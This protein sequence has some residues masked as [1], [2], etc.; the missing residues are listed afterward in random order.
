MRVQK[1]ASNETF[2]ELPNRD[3]SRVFERIA[4]K[5]LWAKEWTH[6]SQQ[7]E[8]TADFTDDGDVM[9]RS[10]SFQSQDKETNE[11]PTS[12][13]ATSFPKRFPSQMTCHIPPHLPVS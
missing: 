3:A 7:K 11:H 1:C 9:E 12:E 13:E 5:Q 8:D 2:N 6:V 10:K 4:Q